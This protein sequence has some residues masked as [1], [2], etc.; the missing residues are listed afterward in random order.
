LL[1]RCRAKLGDEDSGPAIGGFAGPGF[2][3]FMLLLIH[4]PNWVQDPHNRFAL[5]VALREISLSGGALAL[6]ASLT[7]HARERGKQALAAVARY[8]VAIPVF[9]FSFEQFLQGN[10]VP[11]IP[12]NRLTPDWIYGHAAPSLAAP[13]DALV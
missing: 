2:L 3:L 1:H 5:A 13:S 6:A 4:A 11:A 12:L 10:Y 8:F 9:F 7:G